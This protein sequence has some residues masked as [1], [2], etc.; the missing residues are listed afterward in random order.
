MK[1][2]E[3]RW[4]DGAHLGLSVAGIVAIV[5]ALHAA[6][7]LNP[8]TAAVCLLVAILVTATAARLAVAVICSVVAVLSLNF[9]FLPPLYTFRI[10]EPQNWFALAA[11]LIVSVIASQLSAAA[12]TRARE[13]VDRRNELAR[14]YYL[15]RD[16]LLA[17]DRTD[18]LDIL[19]G[20]IA[21]RFELKHVALCLPG[22]HGHWEVHGSG[23]EALGLDDS[24]L[25]AAL[26][27][28][29]TVLEFDARQRTYGG[30]ASVHDMGGNEI[31]LVPLRPGTPTIGL[32]AADQGSLAPG[33]LDA[34]AGLAAIA[35]ERVQFLAERKAADLTR[36]RADLASTLL[37]SLSHDLRTPLTAVSVAIANLQDDAL[38]SEQRCDQ[39]R[40]AA[41]EL[42]RL[43]RLF[44]NI[45]EMARIDAAAL[46]LDR[47]W[48][49]P[50]DV[51]D[52]AVT[53]V[54]PILAGRVLEIDAD[55]S[56][57]AM[58]DPRLTSAALSHLIQNAARYS[59][60]D[61]PIV[62]RGW[63]DAG[64]LQ[65]RVRDYGPGLDP[66]EL[67]QVFERFYRGRRTASPGI[68]TGMGLAIT[69]G[70]LAAEAGRV[71]GENAAGGGAEFSIAVP[72]LSH[73]VP[74]EG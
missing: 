20:H 21:R 37:A 8:T 30:H 40:L 22:L 65:L 48:V 52:A 43:E 6:G 11:F 2:G 32:L 73:A 51:V 23:A 47:D 9:F 62:I 57:A 69:R 12:H 5:A 39:A 13:A 4:R 42:D 72:G 31:A 41:Q 26:A 34:I 10:A 60:T 3:P 38:P 61:R 55:G 53:N 54:R 68:G 49:S 59:P 46:T 64:G 19:A 24:Q 45:L 15:S 29:G 14:L 58:V 18:T 27:S 36:Q 70:L 74:A 1:L 50:A 56:T 25:T 66:E 33:T 67:E 35:V 7:H 28:A 44:G 63:V 71:W 17:T 16:V